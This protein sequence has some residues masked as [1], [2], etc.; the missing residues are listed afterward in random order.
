MPNSIPPIARFQQQPLIPLSQ[1][2]IRP[3][4]RGRKALNV[5]LDTTPIQNVVLPPSLT[6]NATLPGSNGVAQFHLLEDGKTGVLVLGSF[7][8][9]SEVAL[10]R[11]LLDG[12]STLKNQN[13]T[14]L[15]IDV[16]SFKFPCSISRN[17]C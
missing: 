15:I 7:S 8:G 11:A 5:M 17:R 9:M 13:A 16:V 6:P 2:S 1:S 3:N 14:Q 10:E 4:L 12:L